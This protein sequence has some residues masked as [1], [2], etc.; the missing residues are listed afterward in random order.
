[1]LNR[2]VLGLCGFLLASSAIAGCQL[3][4][5]MKPEDIKARMTPITVAQ[6]KVDTAELVSADAGPLEPGQAVYKKACV[7]CH[8]AGVAGAPKFGDKAAW[9][10]R[11]A[12]G[13]DTLLKNS[14]TGINAMPARGTCADCT[15]V[16]LK[17][18]IEYMLKSSQ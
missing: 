12:K 3:K 8:A 14:I 15:D 18:A 6:V 11:A 13:I 17:E 9:S 16:Q 5:S 10:P 2:L 1:M 4:D 7:V